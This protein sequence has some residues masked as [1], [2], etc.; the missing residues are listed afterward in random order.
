MDWYE[1]FFDASVLKREYGR[2]LV[3]LCL[4]VCELLRL[5]WFFVLS[6]FFLTACFLRI[7]CVGACV[8]L[9]SAFWFWPVAEMEIRARAASVIA[10]FFL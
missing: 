10:R 7:F 4:F 6:C 3:C 8:V 9:W 2:V 1:V 5:C